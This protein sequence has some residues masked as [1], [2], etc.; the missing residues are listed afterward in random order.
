MNENKYLSVIII[1]LIVT[2]GGCCIMENKYRASVIIEQEK[3]KQSEIKLQSQ[4][5]SLRLN[6]LI[7]NGKRN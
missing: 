5:D 2:I 7:Q 3:T 6:T 1:V 4:R